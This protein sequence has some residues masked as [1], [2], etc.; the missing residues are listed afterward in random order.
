VLKTKLLHPGILAAL[1]ECGHGSRV[2][3]SDGNFPHR[4]APNAGAARVYLNLSPGRLT[5]TDVLDALVP[6]IPIERAAFMDPQDDTDARPDA[7]AE[8]ARLLPE[9]TPLDHIRR[10]DFYTA[11]AASDVGLVIATADVR[12]YANVLLTIGVVSATPDR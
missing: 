7:H 2:L 4:T 8:I 10:H 1:A 11:T 3:I 9:G 12:P 6:A 5:V